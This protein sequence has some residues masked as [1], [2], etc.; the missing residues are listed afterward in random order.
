MS[1][2]F[3]ESR[4]HP[5]PIAQLLADYRPLPGVYDEM[6]ADDGAVR[7]HWRELLAGLAGLGREELSRRFAAS[8]RYLRESGVFYR[9]YEDADSADRA[10][11]LV[12]YSAGHRGRRVGAPADRAD[13]AGAP[14]R[15]GAGR[16]LRP[17]RAHPRGAAARRVRRRQPGLHAAARQ[18]AA[19]RRRASALLCGRHR[20]RPRRPLVG[21][22]RPHPGAV[23]RG[24]CAGKPPRA[25]PR[26]SRH[27]SQ[28]A[29]APPRAVLPGAAERADRPQPPGRFP[30]LRAHARADE[31]DLF[32]ARL[33][34]PLSRLPPGRGRRPDRARQ[35]RLHPHGF[36]PQAHRGA[37]APARCRFLRSAG[38]QFAV[39]ARRA[40][41][42]AGGARG[43]D[44]ARQRPRQRGGRSARHARLLA[45]ARPRATTATS[46]RCP[47]SRPGGSAIPR[48][49][50]TCAIGSTTWWSPPPS[51]ATCPARPS[52]TA[53][54]AAISRRTA[55]ADRAIDR[56]SRR[57]HR[58]AGGGAAFDHAGVARRSS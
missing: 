24:L 4:E 18:R 49:A 52:A 6:M 32:R 54:A 15:G 39:A 51:P 50:T 28:S 31:R 48:C 29:G 40:R 21:A 25:L 38:A 33:S 58:D 27:L 16:H 26:D 44:R 34:R 36:R 55:P 57:R 56:A 47:T 2:R 10:W 11:P 5:D 41:P 8:D 23:G 22:A 17:D 3:E 43:Q 14:R 35:R 45:G 20:A 46:S 13:R 12:P 19:A 42:G 9:V 7:A 1:A 53:C 37:A 30:G